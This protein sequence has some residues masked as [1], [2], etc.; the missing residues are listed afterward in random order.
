V[1]TAVGNATSE[2]LYVTSLPCYCGAN[3]CKD[4]EE[5][6]APL[7]A[8]SYYQNVV[9]S[10]FEGCRLRRITYDWGASGNTE[11]FDTRTGTF[12]GGRF[13]DDTP[14][15]CPGSQEK[16]GSSLAAGT[17]D[18]DPSCQLTGQRNPCEGTD[19]GP[20]GEN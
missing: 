10:T 20:G 11:V 3:G 16:I 5:S 19:G 1:C 18:V 15:V 17:Y 8:H 6:V 7:C 2:S 13:D 9:E 4:Y 14:G 12:V